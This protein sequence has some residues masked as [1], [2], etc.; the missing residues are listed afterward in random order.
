MSPRKK[1]YIHESRI[2]NAFLEYFFL[3]YKFLK[4]VMSR[5]FGYTAPLW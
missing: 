5:Q 4:P 3:K 1:I 2:T